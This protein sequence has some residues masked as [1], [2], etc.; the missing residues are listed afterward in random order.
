MVKDSVSRCLAPSA[1]FYTDVFGYRGVF[2]TVWGF[3]CAEDAEINKQGGL[4]LGFISVN[5]GTSQLGSGVSMSLTIGQ[6]SW[7][8][9]TGK[10]DDRRRRRLQRE[11]VRVSA[12]IIGD[13]AIGTR[14]CLIT[15]LQPASKLVSCTFWLQCLEPAAFCSQAK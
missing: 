11:H 8:T 5:W 12:I 15:C 4:K 10:P 3:Q 9:G 1:G 13:F 7:S 14:S 6:L 2:G